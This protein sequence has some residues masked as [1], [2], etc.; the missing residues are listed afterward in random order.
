MAPAAPLF[1][2]VAYTLALEDLYETMWRR[3]RMGAASEAIWE[4]AA[5]MEGES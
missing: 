2:V 5:S 4:L 3:P 1:D